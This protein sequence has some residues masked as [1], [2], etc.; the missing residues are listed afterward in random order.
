VLRHAEQVQAA[1]AQLEADARR[2]ID[3]FVQAPGFM[4]VLR[5]PEHVF[6]L[7]NDAYVQLFGRD[8]LIG[9][10]ARTALPEIRG[11]GYLSMLDRIYASGEPMVARAARLTVQSRADAPAEE[12][13]VDFVC[14]PIR[15]PG[16]AVV[17]IFI[18][19]QDVTEQ[20]LAHDRQQTL[21]TTL[22]ATEERLT[23]ALST[24]RVGVF[25]WDIDNDILSIDGPL[26]RFY[27]V[28]MDVAA[29][30]LPIARFVEAI[31]PDDRD[32]VA[33]AVARSVET[34]EPYQEEYRVRGTEGAARSVLARGRIE[35]DGSGR[36]RFV[37]ALIDVTEQKQAETEV[38]DSA[39]RLRLTLDASRMGAW[40]WEIL[41]DAVDLSERAAE[42]F[43]IADEPAATWTALQERLHPED[44]DAVAAA[45]RAAVAERG[46][47]AHE[48]RLRPP[49]GGSE[50]WVSVRG[51]VFCDGHGR[52]ARMFGVVEDITARKDAERAERLLIR[53][54]DHRAKNVM[55]VVQSLVRLTPFTSKTQYVEA[56]SGRINA[57]AR[58]HSLLSR[59]RWFGASL[60]DLIGEELSPYV[61]DSGRFAIEGPPVY[62]KAEGTQ[63]LSLIFH[64]LTTNATKHGALSRPGGSVA[65]RWRLAADGGVEVEWREAGGPAVREPRRD[66]FGATLV[67][68]A[69][70]QLGSRV[71][72]RRWD[73][74]GLRCRLRIAPGMAVANRPVGAEPPRQAPARG[75]RRLP[76]CRVL[77]VEDEALIATEMERA[78]DEAGAAVVGPVGSLEEG[79]LAAL[80]ETFDVAV[81][82]LNLN[83]KSA[84]PL[85]KLLQVERKPFV[86]VTGY[87]Q[88][89][90]H[91]DWVLRKPVAPA[92]LTA[93]L[94]SVLRAQGSG[95]AAG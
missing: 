68:G 55:A 90:I 75:D 4:A 51:R 37:G 27:G 17:G 53:E 83:G 30:G 47:Y 20:A 66:G 38:R 5:G 36:R 26:A 41:T 23:L 73:A 71:L 6:E 10:P 2:L 57:L 7:V 54:V 11:Q 70:R 18:Q 49:A 8:D 48:Y 78:L 14:Q 94:E 69:V 50:R 22:R 42:I 93:T 52:P 65:V 56:L 39:E 88:L 67:A 60:A 15:G 82:D 12:R 63:P 61:A 21:L 62:I 72:E 40:S 87:E 81:L 35:T 79:L 44:R 84:S 34:G 43:G 74:S 24:G 59:N 45:T 91:H 95:A 16:G 89:E 1:N 86:L 46:S 9:R 25:E 76:R 28:P 32:R 33:A 80:H 85:V 3:L 92:E 77:V 13:Y 64:E 31:D 58:A 19:G 29:R